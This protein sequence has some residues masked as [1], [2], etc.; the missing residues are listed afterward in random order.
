MQTTV[1]IPLNTYISL[2]CYTTT[3]PRYTPLQIARDPHSSFSERIRS[4]KTFKVIEVRHRDGTVV[5]KEAKKK[6]TLTVPR[7]E[8]ITCSLYLHKL[9][10]DTMRQHKQRRTTFDRERIFKHSIRI[11]MERK[12]RERDK[13]QFG[14]NTKIIESA[15]QTEVTVFCRRRA[16]RHRIIHRP[17]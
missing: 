3:S 7:H 9:V 8:V 4:N 13:H 10:L 14:A 12:Q 11:Q 2:G 15:P 6:D 1:G 16:K 5:F 17:R